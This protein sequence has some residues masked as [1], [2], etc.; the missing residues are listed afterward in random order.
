MHEQQEFL[1]HI[2][3]TILEQFAF[4]FCELF[5][6]SE[7]EYYTQRLL[8]TSLDFSNGVSGNITLLVPENVSLE[9]TNNVLGTEPD[10]QDSLEYTQDTLNEL[11]NIFAGHV[12]TE[13]FRDEKKILF[14][15]PESSYTKIDEWN[16]L[17]QD[18]NSI[19]LII[20]EE[21]VLLYF[22]YQTTK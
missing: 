3:E 12:F 16:R 4:M 1:I 5:P 9:M 7:I 18:E 20:D 2:F 13:F 17:Q 14:G 19:G 11:V 6:K 10:Q 21:P 8:K 15:I 22:R